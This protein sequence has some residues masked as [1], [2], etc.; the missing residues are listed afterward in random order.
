LSGNRDVPS[1]MRKC[2][3]NITKYVY[4]QSER[5]R[6]LRSDKP[7]SVIPPFELLSHHF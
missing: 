1:W 5:R 7:I 4:R 2:V 6:L 3:E